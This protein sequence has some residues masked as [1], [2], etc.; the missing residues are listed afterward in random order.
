MSYS[1][2]IKNFERIRGYMKDFYVYGFKTREEYDEKSARS[3]DNEKRRIENYLGDYMGFHRNA[4]GKNVFLSID[5]RN[6]SRNPLYKALKA[7]S[8]TNGD[9]TL[10]FI[11]FDILNSPEISRS[12]SE[13]TEQIDEYMSF[14]TEPMAFDESTVRKKLKEYCE[15][16]IIKCEKQ[17]KQVFYRR[18]E[19][20]DLTL[21]EDALEFYSEAGGCGVIGNFMLDKTENSNEYFSFKHHYITHALDSQITAT[22]FSCIT[23]QKTAELVYYSSKKHRENEVTVVP[24]K[25]YVSAQNGR[26]YLISYVK[27]SRSG[28]GINGIKAFRLDYVKKA[29]EGEKVEDYERYLDVFYKIREHMWGVSIGNIQRLEHIEF[30][31]YIGNNEEHIYQRLLREK[32]CGEVVRLDKNTALFYADVYDAYELC[33]WIRSFICRI[34]RLNFSDRYLENRF[35]QDI[36]NMYNTYGIGGGE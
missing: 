7:K 1:E 26:Q 9:I 16:G 23:R 8:F 14:F 29:T 17:G 28:V 10:H 12:L 13:I 31:V 22:L 18:A 11:L 21:W 6:A 2:L 33:P 15:I 27:N 5:S 20:I 3:Y 4:E 19:N 34:K 35:K 32:R 24:L 25:I 36:E 30:T